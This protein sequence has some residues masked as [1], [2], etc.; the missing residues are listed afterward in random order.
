MHF[1][2]RLLFA[3]AAVSAGQNSQN[4]ALGFDIQWQQSSRLCIESSENILKN[5]RNLTSVFSSSCS[6]QCLIIWVFLEQIAGFLSWNRQ[7]FKG[8]SLLSRTKTQGGA[9]SL[10][11]GTNAWKL[12]WT[13]DDW[14]NC[15]EKHLSQQF[16]P[17]TLNN[18]FLMDVWWNNH[19]PF[20][21]VWFIIQLISKHFISGMNFGYRDDI[22]IV[23]TDWNT[24]LNSYQLLLW[25]FIESIESVVVP[26]SNRR[27]WNSSMI[28]DRIGAPTWRWKS[29]NV[30]RVT[31]EIHGF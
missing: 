19:F 6:P 18:Q 24:P 26:L 12:R 23:S 28:S 15:R 17:G 7:L 21:N 5:E 30:K 20:V 25:I 14:E 4:S 8:P 27:L 31:L 10:A 29:S 2:R 22:I 3:V 13:W 11:D 9:F 16:Y 1:I